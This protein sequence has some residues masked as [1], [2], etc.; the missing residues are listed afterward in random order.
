MLLSLLRRKKKGA[1]MT[2]G[3]E[4][5]RALSVPVKMTKSL[6]SMDETRSTTCSTDET[7]SVKSL[8]FQRPPKPL[9]MLAQQRKW[10]E[11]AEVLRR[12]DNKYNCE[13]WLSECTNRK[14]GQTALHLVLRHQPPQ[15]IVALLVRQMSKV[16]DKVTPQTMRDNFGST[17]LH[18]A[19]ES[20]CD[21]LVIETLLSG[22]HAPKNNPAAIIDNNGRYALHLACSKP[23]IA[24]H[25]E[26]TAARIINLLAIAHPTAVYAKDQDGWTPKFLTQEFVHSTR[27]KISK[28]LFSAELLLIKE[29]GGNLEDLAAS[30]A[31]TPMPLVKWEIETTNS[32]SSIGWDEET[33]GTI[34]EVPMIQDDTWSSI[35]PETVTE[36][37]DSV[38]AEPSKVVET[39]H[40]GDKPNHVVPR[41]TKP[42]VASRDKAINYRFM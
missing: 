25:S 11:I 27:S 20:G 35:N 10:S 9:L 19:V 23:V 1:A 4:F 31:N 26:T 6:S 37:T 14:A 8:N 40:R 17:P 39:V 12:Q 3:V 34:Q 30:V 18:V 7:P 42:R 15:S 41:R 28:A 2:T 24:V 33:N 16:N 22:K 13:T 29:H 5:K 21:V 38:R 32:V 36:N